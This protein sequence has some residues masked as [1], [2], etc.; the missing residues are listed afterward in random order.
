MATQTMMYL[1]LKVHV[2]AIIIVMKTVELLNQT[3]KLYGKQGI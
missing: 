1:F 3:L 2:V